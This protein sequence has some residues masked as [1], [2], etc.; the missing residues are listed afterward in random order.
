VWSLFLTKDELVCAHQT[1]LR[2]HPNESNW[3]VAA[4]VR[5]HFRSLRMASITVEAWK[6]FLNRLTPEGVYTVSRWYNPEDPS[7]TGRMLS[8]AVAALM[9][10]H[11]W[12][13]APH[14][15]CDPRKDRYVVII[16][17]AVVSCW[18]NVLEN[19]VAFMNT[20]YS[21]V[22]HQTYSEILYNIVTAKNRKDLERYT[23]S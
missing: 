15:S 22:D 12:T 5:E 20:K 23:S 9:K 21:S 14:F 17:S 6:I 2:Y 18:F 10:M 4:T 8:L 19:T 11:Q 7:E 16:T 3:H 1:N 13:A